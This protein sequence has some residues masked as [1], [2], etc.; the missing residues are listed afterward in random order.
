M[1]TEVHQGL[2][3]VHAVSRKEWRA[4][5][6]KN[7]KTERKVWLII[8]HKDAETPSV[9]YAEA[10]EEALC[11][12]WIDSRPSKRDSESY[13]LTFS[14]RNPRSKWSKINRDR[15]ARLLKD[16]LVAPAGKKMVEIAKKA[17]TWT[18]LDS[19]D[20]GIIPEDL[21]AAFSKSKKAHENFLKFPPGSR[22]VILEWVNSAKRPET[23]TKRI[24]EVVRLAAKNLRAR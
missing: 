14:Q 11:Y 21:A 4:W 2:V 3:A 7:H 6:K 12:G 16:G 10:V 18:A 5:L 24:R 13:Y 8:Y 22:K 19:S 23:R 15:I 9:Y 1:F 20:K 17:G